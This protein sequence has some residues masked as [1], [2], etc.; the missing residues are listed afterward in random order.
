MKSRILL[1]ALLASLSIGCGEGGE[2]GPPQEPGRVKAA[3]PPPGWRTVRNRAAALTVAVPRRWD[4]RVRRGATLVRSPD[5]LVAVSFSR[6]V[7]RAGRETAPRE[8]AREVI[9]ALPGF[10]GAVA[11]RSRKVAGSPYASAVAEG[12]GTVRTSSRPQRI[13]VA[14][15]HLPGRSTHTAVIFRN[16]HVRPPPARATLRRMLARLRVG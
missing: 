4:A 10:E 1:V 8:Y 11:L 7:S 16:A 2:G 5:G 12:T 14:A 9:A 15:F 3:E 6:D 13:T